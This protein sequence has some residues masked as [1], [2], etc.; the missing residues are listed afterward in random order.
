MV[1]LS[2][3]V[4][5]SRGNYNLEVTIIV[6]MRIKINTKNLFGKTSNI[7]FAELIKELVFFARF[8]IL[9]V[10]FLFF[11]ILRT[12]Y[13]LPVIFQLVN[14]IRP[15]RGFAILVRNKVLSAFNFTSEGE[16][17]SV[18]LII[19]AVRHLKAK[20]V[21][22]LITIG[23]MSIGFGSI[24]FLLSLGFGAER[25]VISRVARLEEM[26]QSSVL[27]GQASSLVINDKTIA[28][29]RKINNV[30]AVLPLVSVVSKVSYNNSISDAIGYGVSQQY[31]KESAIK[32]SH[33]KLF[34]DG[35]ESSTSRADTTHGEVAGTTTESS[36]NAK[37]NQQISAIKY[38]IYP[39]EWKT[40]YAQPGESSEIIGYTTRF[41][42]QQDAIEVWG[43]PYESMEDLPDGLDV[44]GNT[45]KPWIKDSFLL[46]QKTNCASIENNCVDGK[47]LVLLDDLKQKQQVGYITEDLTTVNRYLIVP[48]TLSDLVEGQDIDVVKF[49][50]SSDK[51]LET[52]S[53]ENQQKPLSNLYTSDYGLDTVYQGEL[54]YG[55]GY[56][57]E[58]GWGSV[59]SNKNGKGLGL[60]VRAKLPIWR[61]LD[62]QDCDNMYLSE[63]DKQDK[64][65]WT[66]VMIRAS[67]IIIDGLDKPPD[68]GAIELPSESSNDS[69]S[70][71]SLDGLS[72]PDTLKVGGLV[73]GVTTDSSSDGLDNAQD[74]ATSSADNTIIFEDG[75]VIKPDSSGD[76]TVEWV[77]IASASAGLNTNETS[78][79]LPFPSG[80]EREVVVNLAFL[81][82]FNIS[83]SE[84]LNK[85]FSATMILNEEYFD[86]DNYRAETEPTEFIII[87]VIPDDKTPLFYLPFN[88]LRD[89]GIKNYSQI[90][91]IA[92]NQE[93]LKGVRRQI[94]TMGFK[95]NSVVDTVGRINSLFTT[96]KLILTLLGLVALGVAALGMFNTLTV[97]LMEK[98]REVGLMKAIGMKSNEVKRLFLAESIVMGLSGGIFGLVL[99][100]LLGYLLSFLLSMLAIS[101]GLGYIQVIYIPW[102]LGLGTVLLSFV[103]G[104]ITGMYP[105]IRATRISALNAL[106][107]E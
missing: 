47:Y 88:D 35:E 90:K 19:L 84:A 77:T 65:I 59:G 79:K 58:D 96:V 28:D 63:V 53:V 62:C 103:I 40:V 38:S 3:E 91:I 4:A 99:S 70:L 78:V 25:L 52:F 31:L 46:W 54:V 56:P 102:E 66:L 11:E 30:E 86:Q 69:G 49:K 39:L 76:G 94:E 61:K 83:E 24:I 82:V 81:K 89:L 34:N 18:D 16:I 80:S 26:R 7:R 14:L 12:I 42:G 8:F 17:S 92:K 5:Y 13:H 87:G 22:T 74:D 71:S 95:T 27:T 1:D 67:E 41:L 36:I 10:L 64:Q 51:W 9:V 37:L 23:G 105:S 57:D 50:I 6:N 68:R 75:L 48:D 20:K 55:E 93:S 32:P 15:T 85:K 43:R 45:Y 100:I 106:R 21:R 98:T 29:F 104:V 101:K 2:V 107:Y 44:F 33:G 73:L 72:A 97:S 60:W